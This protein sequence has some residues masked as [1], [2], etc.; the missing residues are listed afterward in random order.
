MVSQLLLI[1]MAVAWVIHMVLIAQHGK[2]YFIENNP[3]ILYV[4]I[5]ATIVITVF[6]IIVFILQYNRLG[7]RRSDDDRRDSPAS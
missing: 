2:V 7:E 5:I 1:A 6:A 3:I 4:E